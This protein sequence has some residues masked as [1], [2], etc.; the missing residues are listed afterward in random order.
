MGVGENCGSR[1]TLCRHPHIV[2]PH[3]NCNFSCAR[4]RSNDRKKRYFTRNDSVDRDACRAGCGY[5]HAD[6]KATQ[7]RRDEGG[8]ISSGSRRSVYDDSTGESPS[9]ATK[10]LRALKSGQSLRRARR[11]CLPSRTPQDRQIAILRERAGLV[12]DRQP[13]STAALLACL[14]F[15]DFGSDPGAGNG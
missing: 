14:K 4:W 5:R 10:T 6:L 15:A 3:P 13:P 7:Q 11:L 8:W 2:C 12:P 9:S 1:R